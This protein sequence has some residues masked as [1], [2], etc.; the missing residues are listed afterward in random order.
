MVSLKEKLV[1]GFNPIEKYAPQIGSFPQ[2]FGVKIKNI[3]FETHEHPC[4]VCISLHE[5]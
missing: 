2:R 3:L 4:V 5:R 1:G